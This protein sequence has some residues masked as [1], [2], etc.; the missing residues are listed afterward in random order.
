MF[1]SFLTCTNL[2]DHLW[3]IFPHNCKFEERKKKGLI[4]SKT[5]QTTRQYH[6]KTTVINES[7]DG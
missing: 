1:S 4:W 5:Y 6:K 3:T 7:W 2:D